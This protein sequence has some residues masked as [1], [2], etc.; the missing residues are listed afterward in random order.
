MVQFAFILCL[1]HS[2]EK[3][4]MKSKRRC[5]KCNQED[6][7]SNIA[8]KERSPFNLRKI[9][10]IGLIVVGLSFVIFNVLYWMIFLKYDFD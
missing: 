3:H 9:D 4:F 8:T 6:A 10:Q 7:N 5:L 1:Y 2:N